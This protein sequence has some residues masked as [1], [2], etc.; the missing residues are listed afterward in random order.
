M[1]RTVFWCIYHM[2]L[3]AL[4]CYWFLRRELYGICFVGILLLYT[5]RWWLEERRE[6]DETE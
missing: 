6:K 5:Q 3:I 4:L 1:A 2:V